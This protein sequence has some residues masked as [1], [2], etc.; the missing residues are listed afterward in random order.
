MQETRARSILEER[1]LAAWFDRRLA[2]HA[3]NMRPP[4]SEDTRWYLGTLLERFGRSERLF[5]WQDGASTIRPLAQLYGD[6]LEAQA[7][8]ERCLLLQQLGDLALFLGAVFPERFARR[9]IR[10]DYFVGMGSGAYEYLAGHARAG[11]HVFADLARAFPGLLEVIARVVDEHDH[12]DAGDVLKL[13]QRWLER[14]EPEV[15]RRQRALGV[16]VFDAS[17]LH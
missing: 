9:G 8:H 13:Y 15:A 12:A 14:R 11:K 17:E 6:A 3:Q 4:P 5:S 10:R 7:E 16:D 2:D 1:S